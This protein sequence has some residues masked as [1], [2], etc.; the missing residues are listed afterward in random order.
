MWGFA[1]LADFSH[2]AEMFFVGSATRQRGTEGSGRTR[3]EQFSV[4]AA[5]R[6]RYRQ[7][8]A[9]W[10][11]SRFE[12]GRSIVWSGPGR[13]VFTALRPLRGPLS[14]AEESMS[15]LRGCRGVAVTPTVAGKVGRVEAANDPQSRHLTTPARHKITQHMLTLPVSMSELS[16]VLLGFH[17]TT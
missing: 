11:R 16:L 1:C 10:S 13:D 6:T 5:H 7:R 15:P 8:G 14:R 17:T 9:G 3:K 12:A 4:V 2:V